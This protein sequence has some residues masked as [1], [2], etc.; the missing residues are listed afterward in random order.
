MTKERQAFYSFWGSLLL[1]FCLLPFILPLIHGRFLDAAVLTWDIQK[2]AFKSCLGRVRSVLTLTLLL[3][4]HPWP[5]HTSGLL[6]TEQAQLSLP[7]E[8]DPEDR[9]YEAQ[10]RRS[11]KP[12]LQAE[13]HTDLGWAGGP[14]GGHLPHRVRKRLWPEHP[15]RSIAFLWHLRYP[16]DCVGPSV[17]LRTVWV[18]GGS[19]CPQSWRLCAE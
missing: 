3:L 12:F 15:A 1:T 13:S 16:W 10:R 19:L 6:F 18:A 5:P 7:S 2:T 11:A 4:F 9:Y 14:A 8:T 17:S